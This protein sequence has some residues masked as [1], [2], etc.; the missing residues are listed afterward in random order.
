MRILFCLA[1][2][3]VLLSAP[4]AQAAELNI[5]VF[6]LQKVAADSDSLKEAKSF[7]D[8][9][10]GPQKTELEKER[11]AIEKKAADLE[12]ERDAIAAAP[13][14]QREAKAKALEKKLQDFAKLQRDYS[15]KA[16][17][18]MRILQ[19]DELRVRTELDAIITR[20]A[21]SLAKRKNYSMILDVA[22]VPYADPSLDVTNDM[23]TETNAVWKM[24]GKEAQEKAQSDAAQAAPAAN[25]K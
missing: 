11:E 22:L 6:D 4:Q 7:L 21:Q 23:L 14:K 10:F 8:T 1:V 17:A 2:C 12:K 24:V 13:E 15:E 18:F 3:L 25:G 19:A 5:V 20:A 9:K 16:Q